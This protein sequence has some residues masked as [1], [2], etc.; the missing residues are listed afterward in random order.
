M[1]K[2]IKQKR[3]VVMM[4]VQVKQMITQW[5]KNEKKKQ[6][7]VHSPRRIVNKC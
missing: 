5:K 4:M 1:A 3:G 2:K 6:A 7:F